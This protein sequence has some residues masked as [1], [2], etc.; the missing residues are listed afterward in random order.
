MSAEMIRFVYIQNP[1]QPAESRLDVDNPYN[2]TR[3]LADYLGPLE[4]E[5]AV[6]VSGAI[7][8]PQDWAGTYMLPHDVVV[9][10]PLIFGGG[11]KG[12]GKTILRMVAL[13]AV[14]YFSAG[15]GTALGFTGGAA[16]AVSIGVGIAGSLAVNALLPPAVAKT[17]QS[18]AS[19]SDSP[20]YGVD[21][22]KNLSTRD[23]PV[24][25]I[26]GESWFAGNFVQTYVDNVGDD[27]YLNMLLCIG[28][29]PIQGISE[30]MIND[31]PI[32]NYSGIEVIFRPGTANQP[33]MP[34][35][36][37]IVRPFSRNVALT[38]A[39]MMH[40]VAE[41]VDRLRVDIVLPKGINRLDEEDGMEGWTTAFTLEIREAGGAWRP[42]TNG[43]A[44]ISI[45]GRR[46]SAIRYS[47]WSDVLD[48][49]KRY[50]VRAAHTESDEIENVSNS[51]TVTDINY[52][53][54]DDINYKWTAML[55]LRIK[56]SDQL[57]GIPSVK[58]KVQGRLCPVYNPATGS[59]VETFTKN[60]AWH[61]LDAMMNTRYGGG[62]RAERFKI[63]YFRQWADFCQTN[64]LEFNGPIDQR[65]NLWDAIGP[66]QKLG[67]A[68]VVQAGTRYQVAI[69]RQ[70][71]SA[72]LF[73]S[74]Q[75]KKGSLSIDWLP[76]DERANE[77]RVSYFDKNDGGKQRQVIVA[78][79]RAR[80]RGEENKPT[81]LTLYGCDN[82][83]QAT[84]EGTL[85]MNMQELLK[86]VTFQVPLEA[87]ACTI[88]DVVSLS[89]EMPNWGEGGL[90]EAASTKSLVKLDRPVRFD[91]G[92]QYVVE[93]RHDRV[94]QGTFDIDAVVGNFVVPGFGFNVINFDRFRR[95]L[96][97]RTGIDYPISAGT[98]DQFGRHGLMMEESMTGKIQVGDI[99]QL[100]DTNV[101]EKRL[102]LSEDPTLDITQLRLQTPLS[103][104]PKPGS[105]WS[106]GI[107]EQTTTQLTITGISRK[108][109]LWP[110]LTGLEYRDDAYSDV[111]TDYRPDPINTAPV[112]PNVLFKGFKERRYL[113]GGAYTS[114]IEMGWD[115]SD[116]MYAY[117]EVHISIDDEPYQLKDA[118]ATTYTLEKLN[119]G[120][121]S[122]K[123]VPV[124]IEGFKPAFGLVTVQTYVVAPGVPRNPPAPLNFR[125]GTVTGDVVELLWGDIDAWG[126]SQN[127][128][129]YEI[130]H[131][132]YVNP[133]NTPANPQDMVLLAVTRNNHYPHVGLLPHSWHTYWMRTSNVLAGNVK[134][135]FA[136]PIVVQTGE[137]PQIDYTDLDEQLREAITDASN[138]DGLADIIGQVDGRLATL[139]DDHKQEVFDREE[140]VG[141]LTAH[142]NQTIAT[143]VTADEAL[144]NKV[145]TLEVSV[146]ADIA[147]NINSV[148]TV[149][150]NGDEAL[151][152]EMGTIGAGLNEEITAAIEVERLA[153]VTADSA[154][155]QDVERRVSQLNDALRAAITVES[156]TR[157]TE[158]SA[159]AQQIRTV[160]TNVNG[161]RSA[162]QE[163]V[164][165]VDG[166]SS[167][168]SLRID[169]N[170]I[171]SGFGIA[172]GGGGESEFIINATRFKICPPG[173]AGSLA[174]AVFEVNTNGAMRIKNAIV[175][176]IQSDNYISGVSGWII[177][178]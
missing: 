148:R 64:G 14:S 87:I 83:A 116:P 129:A 137:Q 60:P 63:P 133:G 2:H 113:E 143:L 171:I 55:G 144:A 5:W 65:T 125:L 9:V 98:I 92:G 156:Q 86:T 70:R 59:F 4:G 126:A 135:P 132:P 34:Y 29:G 43:N 6:S 40:T 27:Q 141:E 130:W 122:L 42:F 18:G 115:S 39:Y 105:P 108:D 53:N 166:I 93:V 101:I 146:G 175:G 62:I 163:V 149:I 49:N 66:I 131:A 139:T 95:L 145:D 61:V 79:I 100:I 134:S 169:Q 24:P 28:E 32:A 153:R 77:V 127:V 85:A 155:T 172:T 17:P 119:A 123:L 19:F 84:K 8:E 117:A 36:N 76:A 99:I 158:G 157:V 11:G 160:S 178:K 102:V 3:S 167:S 57:S 56:M 170:G 45:S 10:A 51:I 88:G 68:Q 54:F 12:G 1:L 82:S 174:V 110:T 168:Y 90:V 96:N 121:I 151:A 104:I 154:V 74:S 75:V 150:A 91:Q 47:Y 16:A 50:E 106:F 7:I 107:N 41:S 13:I 26:Y 67:R 161:F 138:L 73:T 15:A 58:Y 120:K 124:T 44:R 103:E 25:V 97:S 140:V 89:H 165:S 35:F 176:D 159:L 37:D 33:L 109:D 46:L 31:Q 71:R 21:G 20:T 147:A 173:G 30:I 94:V 164:E 38:G 22:P 78:N 80:E 112:I 152:L 52:I 142:V 114:D 136:G 81:E 177:K 118:N 72:Q 48:R 162:I 69:V 111:V 128:Y 23:I